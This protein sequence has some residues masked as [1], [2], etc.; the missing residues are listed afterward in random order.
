LSLHPQTLRGAEPRRRSISPLEREM[1]GRA[2][3]VSRKHFR[4]LPEYAPKTQHLHPAQ[5]CRAGVWMESTGRSP[6]ALHVRLVWVGRV[7]QPGLSPCRISQGPCTALCEMVLSTN[8]ASVP[9]PG[10]S[11]SFRHVWRPPG[12]TAFTLTV[13]R[14][15]GKSGEDVFSR[16]SSLRV[17]WW[18]MAAMSWRSAASSASTFTSIFSCSD[19]TSSSAFRFTS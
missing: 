18:W 3:G 9:P 2:E 10:P 6:A 5:R 7:A 12:R 1:P 15:V 13:R 4:S 14:G 8:V 16:Q 11:S 17:T 19:R